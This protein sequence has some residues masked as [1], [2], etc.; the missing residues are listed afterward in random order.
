MNRARRRLAQ[1][2]ILAFA[3][4]VGWV[5]FRL[6]VGN[7]GSLLSKRWNRETAILDRHGQRLRTLPSELGVRGTPIELERMGDRLISA[8]LMSED[9]RFFEHHG[10]DYGAVAR[11]LAQNVEHR[12]IVSGASTV[13]Q[14]LVKLLESQGRAKPRNLWDKLVEAARAQNLERKLSK[15]AILTAYINRLNYGHGLVGPEEA[16]RGMFGK[17]ARQLGWAEAAYLAVLPRAPSALDPYRHANRVVLRQRALLRALADH[18][19]LSEADLTRALDTRIRLQPIAHPF[20]APH[21]VDRLLA[22]N[23]PVDGSKLSTTLDLALQR[24]VL[25]ILQSHRARLAR[26]G[27]DNAAAIVV[28]NQSGEILT[29]VGSFDYSDPLAGQVDHANRPRQ[30][31][32]TLKPFIYALAFSRGKSNLAPLADVPSVFGAPGAGYAPENFDHVFHGPVNARTAL[33]SS[34]NVPAVRLARELPDGA[35]LK[36]LRDA[37]IE[38]LD[39]SQAHYGLS[40]ALGSGEVTLSELVTAYA[41]LARQGRKLALR[42]VATNRSQLGRE[43]PGPSLLPAEF[44]AAVSE[45]LSDPLARVLGLG[46][47]GPFDFPFAVAAKTGTSSGYRD[48]WTLGYTRERTV[49]VWVGNS[50]GAPT[51][52]LTGAQGAGPLFTEIMRRSMREIPQPEPLYDA[53]LLVPVRVCPLSGQ[54]VGSACPTAVERRVPRS[55]VQGAGASVECR[56]HRHVRAEGHGRL[57]RFACSDRSTAS[58]VV[59]PEAYRDWIAA[60]PYGAPGRDANGLPWLLAADTKGCTELDGSRVLLTTPHE[61]AVLLAGNERGGRADVEVRANLQGWLAA[62]RPELDLMVDGKQRATMEAPY[63]LTLALERGDHEVVV[64]SRLDAAELM[65]ARSRFSVR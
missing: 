64:R 44:A 9:R 25:G 6:L 29:Y 52:E 31:G 53:E 14:Q 4:L 50:S 51:R 35:F 18:H 3:C 15:R 58:A 55:Q 19:C 11:A 33:A 17:A 30:P 27:A 22:Q 42:T 48:A 2:A 13:T 65:P 62:K 20:E 8:T 41:M 45:S 5:S 49:G 60:Q 61:G 63:E 56:L 38:S 36:L 37:G 54:P 12:R 28:D 1:L 23:Q 40:L 16:A 59:L 21:F 57:R 43:Q 46:G 26:Q 32:S 10:I 34:L 39:R 47:R 7:P 24:D